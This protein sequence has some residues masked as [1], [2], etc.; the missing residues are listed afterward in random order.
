[1]LIYQHRILDSIGLNNFVDL[2]K[3]LYFKLIKPILLALR[4]TKEH[5]LLRKLAMDHK[6]IEK[7]IMLSIS[8][9]ANTIQAL[10]L[11]LTDI[12]GLIL[13]R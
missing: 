5:S 1:M 9:V 8:K 7:T 12:L 13:T 11:I 3:F 6:I 4:S 10:I 2:S